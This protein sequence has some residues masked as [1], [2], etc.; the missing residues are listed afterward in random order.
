MLTDPPESQVIGPCHWPIFTPLKTGII[1]ILSLLNISRCYHRATFSWFASNPFVWELSN[2]KKIS[3]FFNS[4]NFLFSKYIP[5]TYESWETATQG[6]IQFLHIDQKIK[7]FIFRC[8][9]H[10]EGGFLRWCHTISGKSK[11]LDKTEIC[12]L[13]KPLPV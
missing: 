11:S 2:G 1:W 3:S 7:I 8:S 6:C 10:T 13:S 9:V 5:S 4:N 12:K